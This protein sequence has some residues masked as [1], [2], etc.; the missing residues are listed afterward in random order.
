MKTTNWIV[1]GLGAALL[2]FGGCKKADKIPDSQEVNGVT[3]DMPKLQQTFADTTNDEVRRL[4]T[5]AAFGLRY[6]DYMK[7]MMALDK[8][9]SQPGLTDA[10]KKV[11]SDVIEQEKKLSGA[12][13]PA[14]TQ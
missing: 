11:I 12:A 10:Q 2:V 8:L 14:P 5:E 7:S 1:A 4:V 9:S 3:I 13:A 6:G